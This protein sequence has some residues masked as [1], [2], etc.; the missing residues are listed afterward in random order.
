[1]QAELDRLAHAFLS[2][3]VCHPFDM[4]LDVPIEAL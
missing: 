3:L 2:L 1:M 4:M